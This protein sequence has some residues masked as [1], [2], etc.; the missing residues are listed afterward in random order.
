MFRYNNTVILQFDSD[1]TGNSGAGRLITVRDTSTQAKVTLYEDLAGTV[2]IANPVTS[3]NLGNYTFVVE[4][5]LYDIIVNE[6]LVSEYKIK[7]VLIP[8]SSTTMINESKTA[9]SGET[10]LEFPVVGPN[11]TFYICGPNADDGRMCKNTDYTIISDTEIKLT[12][13]LPEGTVIYGVKNDLEGAITAGVTTFNSRDGNVFPL[14]GDYDA[15]QVTFTSNKDL[16]S[17]RVNT[18]L[19]ELKALTDKNKVLAMAGMV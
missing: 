15:T 8:T 5:G 12:N 7:E 11:A 4:G 1:L 13:S 17:T 16:T 10:V 2:E 19:D 18:A 3:G 9:L 14:D 6:G